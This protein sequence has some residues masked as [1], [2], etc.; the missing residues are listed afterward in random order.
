MPSVSHI[1]AD[2]L[3]GQVEGLTDEIDH[4][5]PV[6]FNEDNRYLPESVTPLPGF[7]RF[8]VNPYMKE[9]LNCFDVN[10]PVREVSL[11][12]GVQ[13]TYTT[14]LESGAFY[15]LGHVKTLPIMYITA[16]AGLASAR[17]ENS[18]LPMLQQSNLEN[19]IRS[20]DIGNTRKTGKTANHIQVEGGG[21]LV[22]FGAQNA[23]KMRQYSIAL[24]LMDEI[25]AWPDVVGK[26]G[27][28]V[29]LVEARC[30]AYWERRKI[31]KGSTPLVLPNSKIQKAF[32][33]GDQREYLVL[34][35]YCSFPQKLRWLSIDKKTGVVGGFDWEMDQGTLVLESVRYCCQNCGKAHYE[36]DKDRLFSADY[37]AYWNPTARPVEPN[38]RSY[39]L[40]AMYSP[41]G[42][43]PWYKCVSDY[44]KGFDPVSQRSLTSPNIRFFTIT[45]WLNL[46][47]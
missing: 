18:F 10:S 34:C 43:Q 38:I 23:T 33:R 15:F 11:K 4:V 13:I 39:H 24:M 42:M 2:W 19:I 6:Q 3:I 8:D 30:S 21:Y 44:L 32:L 9:I 22:P 40:P 7:I 14:I 35:R 47:R 17:I 29:G 5:T 41:S 37:G 27:D 36:H 26:D 25:D 1:G 16:D 12:K 45:F 31:F 28:P 46:S 20:S